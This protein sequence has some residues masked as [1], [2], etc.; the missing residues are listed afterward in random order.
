M[1]PILNY[2]YSRTESD[3]SRKYCL[4]SANRKRFGCPPGVSG[5]CTAEPELTFTGHRKSYAFEHAPATTRT[6]YSTSICCRTMF[7]VFVFVFVIYGKH[8]C[9]D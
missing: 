9:L 3:E 4:P 2:R 6:P 5:I 7:F 8:P 1:K